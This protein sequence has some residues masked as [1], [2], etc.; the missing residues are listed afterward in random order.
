MQLS[1]ERTILNL[2]EKND[3]KEVISSFRE[4]GAV[5]YIKHLQNLSNHE[6]ADFLENKW[7]LS[8]NGHLYYW[9]VREKETQNYIGTIGLAPYLDSDTTFHIGFRISK[10]F[11]GKGLL[12]N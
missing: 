12:L 5:K 10:D 3:F 9:V 1:T 7:L 11:Q 4:E 2:I 6:Y 8:E